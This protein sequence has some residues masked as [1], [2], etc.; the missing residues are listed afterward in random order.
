VGRGVRGP[1][2]GDAARSVRQDRL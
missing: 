1:P 2:A